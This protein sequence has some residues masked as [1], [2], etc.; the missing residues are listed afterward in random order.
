MF[1]L[2]A[3]VLGRVPPMAKLQA[4]LIAVGI[5][6]FVAA[7]KALATGTLKWSPEK[8]LTGNQARM[9]GMVAAALGVVLLGVGLFVPAP[10]WSYF[11]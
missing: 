6:C 10:I 1:Y 9:A 2:A 7:F 5:I 3:N 8:S 11:T 4:V